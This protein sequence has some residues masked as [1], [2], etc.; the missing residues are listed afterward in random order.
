[1]IGKI[2]LTMAMFIGITCAS[3][4][5]VTTSI[6]KIGMNSTQPGLLYFTRADGGNFNC[7]GTSAMDKARMYVGSAFTPDQRKAY[8]GLVLTAK[9][10]GSSVSVTFNSSG[11]GGSCEI[12]D[13]E[14]N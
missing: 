5:G 11:A 10:T 13:I 1:M 6:G 8:L 14:I 4:Q 3:I 12:I 2:A 9:S 7:D